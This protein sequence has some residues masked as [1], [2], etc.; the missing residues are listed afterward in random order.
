MHQPNVEF[1]QKKEKKKFTKRVRE[2][3][4]IHLFMWEK[5]GLNE[6]EKSKYL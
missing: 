2:R 4:N 3:E 5:Y 6:K 1:N